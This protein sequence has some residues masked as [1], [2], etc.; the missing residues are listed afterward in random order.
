MMEPVPSLR[1]RRGDV[2]EALEVVVARALAKDPEDRFSDIREFEQ[3]LSPFSKLDAPHAATPTPPERPVLETSRR[4]HTERIEPDPEE[5]T[6]APEDAAPDDNPPDDTPIPLRQPSPLTVA[7]LVGLLG[8]LASGAV[9]AL[10]EDEPGPAHSQATGPELEHSDPS[11]ETTVPIGLEPP[12]APPEVRIRVT[13]S[14]SEAV[15]YLDGARFPNPMNAMQPRS[16]T[17]TT[18]RVE[19]EGYETLERPVVLDGNRSFDFEMLALRTP[20]AA[21]G[22]GRTVRPASPASPPAAEPEPTPTLT[23]R[24]LRS[25][26]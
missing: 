22:R 19:C 8:L 10:A 16:L 12:P 2:P 26:F 5:A 13:V 6:L 24:G 18:L 25:D 1:S 7:A 20:P 14:P 23:N 3:A 11:A 21:R 9:L 17:P 15:I 4:A